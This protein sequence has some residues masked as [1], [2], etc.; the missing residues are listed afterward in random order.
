LETGLP[1]HLEAEARRAWGLGRD[2]RH[3]L[4]LSQPS[5]RSGRVRTLA[6]ASL[7]RR[8]SSRGRWPQP[9]RPSVAPCSRWARRRTRSGIKLLQV[10]GSLSHAIP[11]ASARSGRGPCLHPGHELVQ[12]LVKLTA[13]LNGVD[14]SP[15]TR[16]SP[17]GPPTPR[18]RRGDRLTAR[19][20]RGRGVRAWVPRGH[21]R[22]S[23]GLAVSPQPPRIP[24]TRFHPRNQAT[25]RGKSAV[26]TPVGIS[27]VSGKGPS[28][29]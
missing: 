1:N 19:E 17:A 4:L 11:V 27:S 22:R 8:T 21:K 23:G 24:T 7:C 29:S 25:N 3:K 12:D 20:R 14:R 18:K 6:S 10:D 5:R 16:C 28:P 13:F 9:H 2:L 26:R 15:S